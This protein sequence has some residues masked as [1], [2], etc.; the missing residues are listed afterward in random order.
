MADYITYLRSMVGHEKVFMAAACAAVGDDEGRILLQKRKSGL[1]GLPGGI[2]ELG[3]AL[4]ET[5]VREAYE[6]TGLEVEPE[7]LIGIY[8]K[9]EAVCANGDKLQ[10]VTALFRCKVTGGELRCDENETLELRY[11]SREELPEI[12]SL[13][14]KDMIEDYFSGKAGNFR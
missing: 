12:Y 5:A 8:S 14:H 11:F 7:V 3:E 2:A 10:P 4:H 6:E 13:Q 9:Y 1:W